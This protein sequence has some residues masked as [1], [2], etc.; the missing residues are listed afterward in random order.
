[1]LPTTMQRGIVVGYMFDDVFSD[2]QTFFCSDIYHGTG[3]LLKLAFS[4]KP[5]FIKKANSP[6]DS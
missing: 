5:R 6:Y 1:M 4:L 2:F 3:I